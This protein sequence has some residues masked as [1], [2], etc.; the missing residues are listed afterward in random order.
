VYGAL[1][2]SDLFN[3]AVLEVIYDMHKIVACGVTRINMN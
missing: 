2:Y 1:L 3:R